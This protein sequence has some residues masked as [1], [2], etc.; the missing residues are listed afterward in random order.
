M[1]TIIVAS[2]ASNTAKRIT[3]FEGT[4]WGELKQNPVV[5]S[6]MVGNVE[7]VL[8]TT[9]ATLNRED[10]LLPTEGDFKV[11]L[12]PTKNS[13]GAISEADAQ[14][15]AADIAAA[16]VKAS[17]QADD[18]EIKDL[19]EDLISAVANF[20]DVDLDEADQAGDDDI[21]GALE[22]LNNL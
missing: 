20:Y 8:S 16:I 21:Q 7:A 12:I 17:R 14:K 15:L 5:K 3:D 6:L 13:A 9:K 2:S 11:F 22:E 1:R 10:A 18:Q 4:T 19:K